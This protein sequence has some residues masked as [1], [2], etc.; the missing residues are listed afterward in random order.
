MSTA[1]LNAPVPTASAS[2]DEA[3]ILAV[4]ET[5]RRANHDKNA[6][7]FAAQFAPDAV[8]YNLAP[9]LVHHGVDVREKQAWLDSWSTPVDIDA[10]D[11]QVTVAGDFAFCHGYLRLRGTKK[12]AE[13]AVSFWMRET[14]CLERKGNGW[15][16]VHEHTSV[17]FY[18]DGTLRPAFDL[19]P[20]SEA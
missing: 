12:G 17:P 3:A 5:M 20:E 1:T 13:G 16:I 8:I 14:L 4:V 10:R 6:A 2:H 18:M 9:P 19:K 7:L 15:Q 11:L